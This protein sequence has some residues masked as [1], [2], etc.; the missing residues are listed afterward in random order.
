MCQ[1]PHG[2]SSYLRM[3]LAEGQSDSHRPSTDS[4]SPPHLCP[5]IIPSRS[6]R[7][8][9]W[10]VVLASPPPSYRFQQCFA[11]SPPAR[12]ALSRYPTIR[13]EFDIHD[14]LISW[15]PASMGA[16]YL[17][18]CPLPA[19]RDLSLRPF[20]R[21]SPLLVPSHGHCTVFFAL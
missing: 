14:V 20:V 1:G 5:L 21:S 13:T 9:S 6:H 11:Y 16:P 17:W 3:P 15:T 2:G 18:N 4:P 7:L 19:L 12:W 10:I 8:V